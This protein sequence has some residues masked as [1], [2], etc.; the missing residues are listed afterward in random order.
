MIIDVEIPGG[1]AVSDQHQRSPVVDLGIH[2]VRLEG[3]ASEWQVG[4]GGSRQ[5]SSPPG[6]RDSQIS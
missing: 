6:S 3:C 5:S 1:L 2:A 4:R